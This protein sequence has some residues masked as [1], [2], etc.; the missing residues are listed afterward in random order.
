MRVIPYRGEAAENL[1]RSLSLSRLMTHSCLGVPGE[2]PDAIELKH[3]LMDLLYWVRRPRPVKV[4]THL[5]SVLT[6]CRATARSG[7]CSPW[8]YYPW[9]HAVNILSCITTCF[10]HVLRHRIEAPAHP[11]YCMQASLHEQHRSTSEEHVGNAIRQHDDTPYGK[12]QPAATKGPEQEL[13]P[14]TMTG[15]VVYRSFTTPT[16]ARFMSKQRELQHSLHGGGGSCCTRMRTPS[17]QWLVIA[18]DLGV[19]RPTACYGEHGRR[20]WV[21]AVHA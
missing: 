1:H 19:Q 13:P 14:S 2:P 21:V 15:L 5:P 11:H 17:F 10:S 8:P 16:A 6:H 7:S 9:A 20:P 4:L 12:C 18:Q 3:P